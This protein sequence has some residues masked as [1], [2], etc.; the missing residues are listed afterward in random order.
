MRHV[1]LTAIRYGWQSVTVHFDG[2]RSQIIAAR[3][4]LI[5]GMKANALLADKGY[6]AIILLKLHKVW[7]R[8]P[9]FRQNRIELFSENTTK[10][11]IKSV[12]L[13]KDYSI[14]LKISVGSQCDMIK[15]HQKL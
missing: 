5:D 6:D 13:L 11:F 4:P 2:G 1:K 3:G 8:S 14:N 7:G 12:T 15:L 10:S 9:S